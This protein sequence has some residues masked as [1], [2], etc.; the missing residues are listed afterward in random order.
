MWL[1]LVGAASTASSLEVR[2]AGNGYLASSWTV[3][4]RGSRSRVGGSVEQ[5]ATGGTA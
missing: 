3:W 5:V 4:H 1:Q 2:D